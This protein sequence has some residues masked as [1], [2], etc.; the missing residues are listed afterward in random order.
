[1]PAKGIKSH[2]GNVYATRVSAPSTYTETSTGTRTGYWGRVGGSVTRI[3][4]SRKYDDDFPR[5]P[6][7][8][9]STGRSGELHYSFSSGS[10][11]PRLASQVPQIF[12]R[13]YCPALIF[14]LSLCLSLSLALS[15]P[16]P[17]S[18]PLTLRSIRLSL[19]LLGP[20][21]GW[22]PACPCSQGPAQE[23]L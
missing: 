15:F 19:I 9:E 14:A 21:C 10:A 1:M 4:H 7:I 3:A 2:R 17:V 5:L 22:I 8:S 23:K 13:L 12:Q 16:F 11:S 18:F 20:T 6:G